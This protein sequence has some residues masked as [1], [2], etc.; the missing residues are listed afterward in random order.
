[1][2]AKM[3]E[4]AD[5]RPT[6]R[7]VAPGDVVPRHSLKLQLGSVGSLL[8]VVP[9]LAFAAATRDVPM[10]FELACAAA[11]L[12]NAGLFGLLLSVERELIAIKFLFAAHAIQAPILTMF[13]LLMTGSALRGMFPL[14]VLAESPFRTALGLVSV[15]LGIIAIVLLKATVAKSGSRPVTFRRLLATSDS[16]LEPMLIISALFYLSFAYAIDTEASGKIGYLLRVF[17]YATS[18]AAFAAGF[19]L[20]RF[21][22]A[23]VIWIVSICLYFFY[24]FVTGSRGL[25]FVQGGLF[26]LG[27]VASSDSSSI[28]WKRVFFVLIPLLIP[29]F[30]LSGLIGEVRARVGRGSLN[31][32][33]SFDWQTYH[34]AVS[35]IME[36]YR[37]KA[38]DEADAGFMGRGVARM[39][40]WCNAAVPPM[41]PEYVPYRG[42]RD[43]PYE[44]RESLSLG[45]FGQNAYWGNLY[46]NAYGFLTNE[47]TSIEFGLVADGWSRGGFF[48]ALLYSMLAGA[49]II[50]HELVIRRLFQRQTSVLVFLLLVVINQ[51]VGG[52]VRMGLVAAIRLTIL[53]SAAVLVLCMALR[54]WR[55]SFQK[56]Q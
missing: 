55:W 8:A 17:Y 48:G 52:F 28:V 26:L 2:A 46:S 56:A 4:T 11:S 14:D 23:A 29:M 3:I 21:R 22:R 44:V 38:T 31:M 19:H 20:R 47:S 10:R 34:E 13:Y 41:S 25:A 42:Y 30:A 7:F 24:A 37:T 49:Y 53:Y 9:F 36:T 18:F 32:I 39:V 12:L 6:A 45:L 5:Q 15:P 35:D 27:W 51:C 16:G 40:Q 50:C 1:M 54:L 33:K 43:L